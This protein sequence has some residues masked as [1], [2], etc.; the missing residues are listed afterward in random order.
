MPSVTVSKIDGTTL[1]PVRCI[2]GQENHP[3]P[4]IPGKY[5]V[6]CNNLNCKMTVRMWFSKSGKP[7]LETYKYSAWDNDTW[8]PPDY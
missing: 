4:F 5:H 6:G 1:I 8:S 7:M 3:M 2:C